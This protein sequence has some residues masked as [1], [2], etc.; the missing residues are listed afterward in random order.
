MLLHYEQK[1]VFE[2]KNGLV[3]QDMRLPNVKLITTTQP[4]MLMC[5]NQPNHITH[6]VNTC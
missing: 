3:T 1:S 6:R 5:C 4:C 2:K